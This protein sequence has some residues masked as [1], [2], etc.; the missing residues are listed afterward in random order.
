MKAKMQGILDDHP[1]LH[2]ALSGLR[3]LDKW[4]YRSLNA[5]SDS[6]ITCHETS[7]NCLK[8]VSTSTFSR[9]GSS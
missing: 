7:T 6:M 5:F 3:E 2:C 9:E 1:M 8:L 4:S